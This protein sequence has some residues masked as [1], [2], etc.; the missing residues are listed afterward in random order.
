[1]RVYVYR[2]ICVYVCVCV[3]VCTTID[4]YYNQIGLKY[5]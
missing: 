4:T 2:C 5:G 1:M 3:C